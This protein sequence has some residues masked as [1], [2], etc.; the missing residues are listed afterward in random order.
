MKISKSLIIT[1]LLLILTSCVDGQFYRTVRGNGNVVKKERPASYFDGISV[2]TGIDVYLSQGDGEKII[3]EADENL[4]DYLVTEVKDRTLRIYFDD[5]SIRSAERKRVYVTMKDVTKLKTSSAGDI[6]GETPVKCGDILLE[7]SSAGNIRLE[8]YARNANVKISS[9]GDI[10]LTGEAETLNADLSS[11]GDLNA[12]D[13][14]VKDADID[15]SSAGD[16]DI[17][18]THKLVARVS[19]AGD[20]RY[21]GEPEIIDV[22]TSSAGT[23]RKR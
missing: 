9:S 16:A 15:V 21:A 22:R 14:K 17:Y 10:S 7:S 11:A 4:H 13:F 3:V 1:A 18:V 23:V 6:I 5:V 12:W 8:L 19:S 20:V 2:S